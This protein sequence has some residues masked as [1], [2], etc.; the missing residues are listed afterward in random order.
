MKNKFCQFKN[1]RD[2]LKDLTSKKSSL[3]L[4]KANIK[5]DYNRVIGKINQTICNI[6]SLEEQIKNMV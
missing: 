4:E 5:T 1:S 2:V 3:I 6:N